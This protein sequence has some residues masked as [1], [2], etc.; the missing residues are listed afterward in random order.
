MYEV[1]VSPTKNQV[2]F[3]SLRLKIN[4]LLAMYYIAEV[5]VFYSKWREQ[6]TKI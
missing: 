1:V 2:K 5:N 3:Y 4:H 6:M